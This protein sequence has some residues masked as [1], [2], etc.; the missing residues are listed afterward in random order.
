MTKAKCAKVVRA[1]LDIV[2]ALAPEQLD[3]ATRRAVAFCRGDVGADSI[4][5]LRAEGPELTARFV[6]ARALPPL[7]QRKLEAALCEAP[8]RSIRRV[9]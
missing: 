7:K 8:V 3:E 5:E 6:R 9:R 4:G 1:V 2:C